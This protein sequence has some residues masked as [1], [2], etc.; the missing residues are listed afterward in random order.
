M[1]LEQGQKTMLN[2]CKIQAFRQHYIKISQD[3]EVENTAQAHE[4]F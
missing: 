3:S 4:H 2:G 1:S